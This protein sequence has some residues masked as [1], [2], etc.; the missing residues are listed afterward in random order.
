MSTP[1]VLNY[2]WQVEGELQGLPK[3]HVQVIDFPSGALWVWIGDSNA[4]M[5]NLS[6]SLNRNFA[7]TKNSGTVSTSILSPNS[8][9][10][11][12]TKSKVLAQKLSN[13]LKGRPVFLSYAIPEL[14]Y[15]E[16]L[17]SLPDMEIQL[18]KM[19]KSHS[20]NE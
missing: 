4:Q 12:D 3:I 6:L 17:L 15:A 16:D 8:S 19:L 2:A 10:E 9:D 7:K 13:L 1:T 14:G 20:L 5:S 11:N 18:F